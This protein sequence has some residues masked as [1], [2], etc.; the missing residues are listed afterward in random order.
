MV[1]SEILKIRFAKTVGTQVIASTIALNNATFL[2]A[3]F[4]EFVGE[5]ATWLEIAPN[6]GASIPTIQLEVELP[7]PSILS[8]L[9]S[10]LS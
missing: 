10:W 1:P 6:G 5:P 4:A 2:Q 8:T 3:S 9:L 7:R